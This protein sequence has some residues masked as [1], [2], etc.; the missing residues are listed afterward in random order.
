MTFCCHGNKMTQISVKYLEA[1]M[2]N[3]KR[4]F[5]K[6]TSSLIYASYVYSSLQLG[7]IKVFATLTQTHTLEILSQYILQQTNKKYITKI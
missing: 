5:K 2:Y 7:A 3:K 6:K 1:Q 4:A